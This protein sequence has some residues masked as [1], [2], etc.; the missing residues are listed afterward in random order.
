MV[1]IE[2]GHEYEKRVE[3]LVCAF[4]RGD[5]LGEHIEAMEGFYVDLAGAIRRVESGETVSTFTG[6]AASLSEFLAG[7]RSGA[8]SVIEQALTQ[9]RDLDDLNAYIRKAGYTVDGID[10]TAEDDFELWQKLLVT[11]FVHFGYSAL[12]LDDDHPGAL[13]IL[14][15]N[16]QE[17]RWW[18][19][20]ERDPVAAFADRKAWPK[21]VGADHA[22]DTT[23]Q[24][25][26][27]PVGAFQAAAQG[28]WRVTWPLPIGMQA[29]LETLGPEFSGYEY[30]DLAGLAVAMPFPGNE[31]AAFIFQ[32]DIGDVHIEMFG[33][34]I[35][36]GA[37]S[38]PDRYFTVG[39]AKFTIRADGPI[40]ASIGTLTQHMSDWWRVIGT[41]LL[42]GR[43]RPGGQ[44]DRTLADYEQAYRD[45]AKALA[46]C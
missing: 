18:N 40:P 12:Y 11:G 37:V 42:P 35:P 24:W 22:R 20:V 4:E 26:R 6:P 39:P 34:E 46:G 3:A 21:S 33:L 45:A 30:P 23:E 7:L 25:W 27:F 43:G 13:D 41:G 1:S 32:C 17:W 15:E 8:R 2:Y 29:V 36:V 44:T 19:R 10:Q 16:W 38:D 28:F 31:Y 14:K 9:Q 5:D